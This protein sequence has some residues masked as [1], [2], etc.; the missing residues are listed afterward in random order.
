MKLKKWPATEQEYW[1]TIE[2]LGEIIWRM[3]HDL[4]D[5]R[6][7]DPEG[8][9]AQNIDDSQKLLEKLVAELEEKFGIISTNHPAKTDGEYPDPPKGQ[10]WYWVWYGEMKDSLLQK[11]YEEIICSACPLS[12]GVHVFSYRIP[13]SIF[14]GILNRLRASFLC[15]MLCPE[16]GW[17][18]ES[19]LAEMKKTGGEEGLQRFL[20]KEKQLKP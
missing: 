16:L 20:E 7:R 12:E 10:R 11:E 17:M 19:L 18:R 4:A 14:P 15:E 6:I 3:D 1:E 8:R 13:C 9:V 5:G 2:S